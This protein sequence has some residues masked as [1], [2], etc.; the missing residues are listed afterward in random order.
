MLPLL[1]TLMSR[2][3]RFLARAVAPLVLVGLVAVAPA[4]AK[5]GGAPHDVQASGGGGGTLIYPS[6]VNRPLGR[7]ERALGRASDYVDK[8]K[9]DKAIVALKSAR[10]NMYAAWRGAKYLIDHA[11]PPAPDSD[12]WIKSLSVHK[13]GS[14]GPAAASVPETA[15][16]V[17]TLQHD[18]GTTAFDIMDG[19]K[20]TLLAAANTT[21]FAALNRRDQAIA[22]IHQVA[23]PAPVES[24]AVRS[25][26]PVH[27]SGAPVA[28]TFDTVMPGLVPEFDDELQQIGGLQDGGALVPKAKTLLNDA[29]A[30]IT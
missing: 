7:G 19:G 23:P 1:S 28:V 5:S 26:G 27:A 14:G 4:S 8:D 2:E 18:A 12:G 22:Y 21:V 29:Q 20:G 17:L 24:G 25:S 6:I 9:S 30:Q 11:P 3:M 10:R 16:A 15:F 13:A